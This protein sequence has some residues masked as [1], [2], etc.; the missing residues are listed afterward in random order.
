MISNLVSP[1]A[2]L[3]GAMVYADIFPDMRPANHFPAPRRIKS[4]VSFYDTSKHGTL[5]HFNYRA[6]KGESRPEWT[7]R[8]NRRN[9]AHKRISLTSLANVV[10]VDGQKQ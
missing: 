1:S 4:Y 10:D 9:M 6:V 8:A 7:Y 3:A 5:K 2:V